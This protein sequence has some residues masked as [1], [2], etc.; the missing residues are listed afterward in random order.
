[1]PYSLYVQ[2]DIPL[3]LSLV[4]AAGEPTRVIEFLCDIRACNL[5][6]VL[7][8][9]QRCAIVGAIAALHFFSSNMVATPE[10]WEE[11]RALLRMTASDSYTLER[12]AN[13]RILLRLFIWAYLRI[14]IPLYIVVVALFGGPE[15]AQP[16][17]ALKEPDADE[18]ESAEEQEESEREAGKGPEK[19][20]E[21]EG[22]GESP[23]GSDGQES[24]KELE[25]TGEGSGKGPEGQ[26]PKK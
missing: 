8:F 24:G 5:R 11:F 2:L 10:M 16:A 15:A 7:D 18:N 4:R 26:G 23:E 9:H 20:G 1:M 25:K 21:G 22:S 6:Q 14:P 17:E 19:K 12:S 13:E 3:S